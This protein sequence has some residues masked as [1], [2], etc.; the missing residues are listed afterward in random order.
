VVARDIGARVVVPIHW[1][2]LYPSR[3]DRVMAGPLR[4]PPG[5]LVRHAAELCPSVDVRVLQ[6]GDATTIGR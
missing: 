1:G 5:R 6:P 3:L 2:T 4:D